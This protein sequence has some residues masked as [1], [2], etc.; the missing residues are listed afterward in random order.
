MRQQ[1]RTSLPGSSYEKTTKNSIVNYP[2]INFCDLC[3]YFRSLFF[4]RPISAALYLSVVRTADLNE[5]PLTRQAKRII[6]QHIRNA[7]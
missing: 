7:A 5:L 3:V 2:Y 1:C 4:V 6:K